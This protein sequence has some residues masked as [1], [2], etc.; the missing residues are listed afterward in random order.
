IFDTLGEEVAGARVLDLYAGAGNMGLEALSRGAKHCT[1]IDIDVESL[2]VI[3]QNVKSTG[4]ADRSDILRR[5][6]DGFL[7]KAEPVFDLVFIDPPFPELANFR[8][9]LL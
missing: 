7:K 3:H 6:A 2:R 8:V 4:F 9:E 5:E 1:F